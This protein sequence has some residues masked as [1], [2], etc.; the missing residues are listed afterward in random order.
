MRRIAALVILSSCLA[1]APSAWADNGKGHDKGHGHDKGIVVHE[2][3]RTAVYSYYRT[4][5]IGGRCPPGLAKKGNG[6]LPP[7]VAKRAW[8]I[9]APLA[10]AVAFY[11]L[12][13]N[14]LAQLTPAPAGYQYVRVDNDVL[15]IAP[16]TR[17]VSALVLNLN[18]LGGAQAPLI[19][20]P[21][22]DAIASYYRSNYLAGVC[23]DGLMRTDVGCQV[24][25]LWTLGMPLEPSVTYEVLPEPLL[26]QLSPPPDGY[27][28]IRLSDHVLLMAIETR[29]IRADILDLAHLPLQIATAP[30]A[31]PAPAG[32]VVQERIEY[33]GGGCPPG[34]AKKHNGCLPPGH[35]K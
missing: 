35:A 9:G 34:L 28:Y 29:M 14:L 8:L 13:A 7:G 33:L 21:D 22:R 20:G 27:Q 18:D 23:P 24:R 31:V 15:L 30:A 4:E 32:A 1:V 6:C 17:M 5:F 19:A 26:A 10:P 11:P 25:P 16:Q 2:R 3:D 12:P